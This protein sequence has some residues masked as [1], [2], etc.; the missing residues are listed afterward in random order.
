[1]YQN[2]RAMMISL[3]SKAVKTRQGGTASWSL[4]GGITIGTPWSVTKQRF[5]TGFI[6][7]NIPTAKGEPVQAY[8]SYRNLGLG[9]RTAG[10]IIDEVDIF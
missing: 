7:K 9:F 8:Y 6:T 10:R 4:P 3:H 5:G 2:D 1:M